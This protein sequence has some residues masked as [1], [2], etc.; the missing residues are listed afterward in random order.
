[1]C[2]HVPSQATHAPWIAGTGTPATTVTP[3][4]RA[5]RRL[6]LAACALLIGA[7]VQAQEPPPSAAAPAPAVTV[8]SVVQK[9]VTPSVTFNGRIEAVDSVDLRA[10]VEGFVAA[11]RFVE[12]EDVETGDLL[13]VLEKD[14]Y[15]DAIAQIRGQITAAEGTLLLADIEVRRQETLV[16][17]EAVAQA[18]LDQATAKH[19]QALGDLQ[20][21]QAALERAELD[22]GYTD[23]RAPMDGRI[24]RSAYSVGDV[25][26]PSSG[27]LAKIVSQDPM[28]VTFPV[29][30]RE[31]LEVLRTSEARGQ[32]PRSVQVK[33]RLPDGSIYD[34]TGKIDFLDVEVDPTTDTVIVRATIQN[35]SAGQ[36]ERILMAN[37]LVG[38]II[39]QTEPERA[40]VIPQAAVAVDQAGPFV[41]VVGDDGTTEQRRIS[42]GSIFGSETTVTGGL[43]GGERV[44]VGG[45]Q[46]VRPGQVVTATPVADP[47]V[48]R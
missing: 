39:E 19:A 35:T 37:Q 24:G 45:L 18:L 34:Q 1:M 16:E 4:P 15:E 14:A 41:L 17:R 47:G 6:S 23:I 12:G 48:A 42:P 11:R 31:L 43:A 10:R 27:A 33:L 26:G 8:A 25:V 21:L 46:K 5:R 44:V 36:S 38:V 32:D 20:R 30:A 40:L 7:G 28:Y 13:F 29:T 3:S 2:D 9:D 22:L